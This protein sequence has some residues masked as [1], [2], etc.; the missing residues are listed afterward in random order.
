[1]E[2]LVHFASRVAMDIDTLGERRVQQLHEHGLIHNI[3]DIYDLKNKQNELLKLEKMGERS[4]EKLL[5]AIE[6]SKKQSLDRLIFGLGIRHVGAKT[7]QVLAQHFKSLDLL[8]E[9][10]YEDLIEIDE[11]GE[12]IAQ[13]LVSFFS[14]D[15]NIE[16]IG[17]LKKLGL[18]TVYEETSIGSAF[19]DMR[20]VLTGTLSNMTRS[21]AKA[22][23]E[24][25]G[26]RVTG[27]VSSKT[28][29][30]VYGEQAGS[31]LEKALELEIRTWTEEEFINEVSKYEK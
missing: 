10:K 5:G 29:V 22:L 2:S 24:N 9:A 19:T 3:V 20:F 16:L 30:V 18:N 26:G 31:K 15:D 6:E 23:I 13:S 21:E 17:D 1:V 4:I 12:I 8:A 14:V 27:T 7:S 11:I 25:L 28:D